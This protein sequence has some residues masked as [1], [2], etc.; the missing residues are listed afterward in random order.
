MW[1]AGTG[2]IRY[3]RLSML[4]CFRLDGKV[5]NVTGC[6]SGISATFALALAEYGANVSL[7]ARRL[8][9]MEEIY[10]SIGQLGRKCR[11]SL[12]DVTSPGQCTRVVERTVTECGSVYIL[13]S[14]ACIGPAIVASGNSAVSS[15]D[16]RLLDGCLLD[17][18]GLCSRYG[19]WINGERV[20]VSAH[21]KAGLS[22]AL[23]VSNKAAVG[24]DLTQDVAQQWT[25][26]KH[27]RVNC[28]I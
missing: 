27:T 5:A 28:P 19:W 2:Y 25:Q 24:A 15:S 23:Y 13:G 9:P 18:A 11:T 21:I 16:R 12:T 6:S 8:E 7:A 3:R 17:S 14:S 1:N 10:R 22:L 20:N 4:Q 26:R